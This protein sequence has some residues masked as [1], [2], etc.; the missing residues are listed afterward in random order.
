MICSIFKLCNF[1]TSQ[2]LQNC[3][4]NDNDVNALSN[5]LFNYLDDDGDALFK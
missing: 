4:A 3:M 1:V 2:W 5:E